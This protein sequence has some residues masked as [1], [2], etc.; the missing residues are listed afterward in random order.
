MSFGYS[1]LGFGSSA[2][3]ASGTSA[4]SAMYIN[5]SGGTNTGNN[6]IDLEFSSRGRA[7]TINVASLGN[8]LNTPSGV[9]YTIKAWAGST[10]T[11]PTSYAWGSGSG[12]TGGWQVA[13]GGT[14]SGVTNTGTPT[15]SVYD[16]FDI[17]ITGSTGEVVT[18]TLT[19]TGTNA[20]GST[21]SG[22]FGFSFTM[23]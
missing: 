1:V 5:D 16:D 4:P 20:G 10:G 8:V 12:N 3:I 22:Q 18:C 6:Y 23:A 17:T 2:T 19:L 15:G 11:S 21:D 7:S 14:A 13:Y 9:T